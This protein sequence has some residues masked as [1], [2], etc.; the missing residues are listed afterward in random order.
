MMVGFWGW[1]M[2]LI[3]KLLGKTENIYN[4]NTGKGMFCGII[5]FTGNHA[6]M[7]YGSSV[8]EDLFVPGSVGFQGMLR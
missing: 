7:F 3:P 6:G 5:P 2:N 4:G 1:C 8:T